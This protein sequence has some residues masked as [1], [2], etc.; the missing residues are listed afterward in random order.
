[1]QLIAYTNDLG[2]VSLVIAAPECGLSL[3]EIAAKDIPLLNAEPRPYLILDDFELPDRALRDRW[4]LVNGVVVIGDGFQLAPQPN[5][6]AFYEEMLGANG[7]TDLTSV[8]AAVITL[9]ESN[10]DTST[11]VSINIQVVAALT[12]NDWSKSYAPYALAAAYNK[13]KVYL[14]DVQKATV[15]DAIARYHLGLPE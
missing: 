10:A 4:Q 8:F 11:L 2:D 13:L 12:T 9:S 1:M 6:I 15:E 7:V 5:P 14:S 3:E